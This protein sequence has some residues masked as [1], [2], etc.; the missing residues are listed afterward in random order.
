MKEGEV[1]PAQG[2]R[3]QIPWGDLCET[4]ILL[5]AMS[6]YIGD[7]DVTDHHCGLV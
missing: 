7:P 1:F 3:V 6:R 5:L 4:G 2:T